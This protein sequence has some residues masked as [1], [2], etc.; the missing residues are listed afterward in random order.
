MAASSQT[1][2]GQSRVQP[3]MHVC[4]SSPAQSPSRA[5]P[6]LFACLSCAQEELLQ[7]EIEDET[8]K[9]PTASLPSAD[10]LRDVPAEV[11]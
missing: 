2:C 1:Q 7:E 9:E 10:F 3:C 8:D 4:E 6:R 5:R 11:R